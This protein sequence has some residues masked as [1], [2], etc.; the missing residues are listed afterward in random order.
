MAPCGGLRV[1]RKANRVERKC[2][3][4][5][6]LYAVGYELESPAPMAMSTYSNPRGVEK[7]RF[8]ELPDQP[9]SLIQ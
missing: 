9:A 6:A 5:L 2:V 7:G 8:Q 4:M 1:E 3:R